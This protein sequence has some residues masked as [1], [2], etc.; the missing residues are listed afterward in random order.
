MFSL[1]LGLVFYYMY[2]VFEFLHI[3]NPPPTGDRPSQIPNYPNSH[4]KPPR[5]ASCTQSCR[6]FNLCLNIWSGKWK[7]SVNQNSWVRPITDDDVLIVI[8]LI[9]SI[10]SGFVVA[11]SCEN[12]RSATYMAMGS[13]LPIVMLCGI[14]WPIEGMNPVLRYISYLLPL[15]KSTESFRSMLA[16]GWSISEPTVYE[17]FIATF[18]WI[19][20]FQTVAILLIKF[21]KGWNSKHLQFLIWRLNSERH[22]NDL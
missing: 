13:F 12:E 16:R 1:W 5:N 11:C 3:E 18:V 2:T 21:K 22:C 6:F 10:F 8:K 7:T 14:I 20:I 15:T 17:G 19:I 9:K 4:N